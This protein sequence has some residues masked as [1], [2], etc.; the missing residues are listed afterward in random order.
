M[1]IKVI[2]YD[3]DEFD[4]DCKWFEFRCNHVANWIE[5]KHQDGNIEYIHDV[6][7]IKSERE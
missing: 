2:K 3:G 4:I 5:V 6:C 1:K 7:V